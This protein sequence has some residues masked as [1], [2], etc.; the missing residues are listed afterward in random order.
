[1][2]VLQWRIA[3]LKEAECQ[4]AVEDVLYMI[5]LYKFSQNRVPLVPSL[6]KCLYNGRLEILPSKDWELESIH[7]PEVLEMVKEHLSTTLGWNSGSSVAVNWSTTKIQKHHLSQVY[8]TSILYGYFLKS[9]SLRLDLEHNLPATYQNTPFGSWTAS[10]ECE[11]YGF[12]NVMLGQIM[13]TPRSTTLSQIITRRPGKKEAS[14]RWYV[15][16]FDVQ[17]MEECTKVKSEEAVELINKHCLALFGNA[18][19]EDNEMMIVTSLSSLKRLVLEAV[20]FGCF[21]WDAEGCVNNIY[22]LKDRC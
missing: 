4:V 1:M 15:T 16:G 19:V 2:A 8:A 20:A 7:S 5:I 10:P 18:N 14:L 13:V 12:K 3:K 11:S 9:A 22:K 6:S 21:L 17:T